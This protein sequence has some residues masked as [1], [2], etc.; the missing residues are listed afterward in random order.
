MSTLPAD[1]LN[2]LGAAATGQR[3][4]EHCGTHYEAHRR[5]ARFCSTACR[6]AHFDQELRLRIIREYLSGL[7]KKGAAAR[8]ARRAGV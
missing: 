8:K 2:A 3:A 4:C 5:W 7:G 1:A 6:K